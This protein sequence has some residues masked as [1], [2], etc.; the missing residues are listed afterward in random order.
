MKIWIS[1]ATYNRKKITE[2][3]LRQLATFKQDS[4]LHVTD[5]HSSEYDVAFLKNL[6]ADSV[7]QPVSKLGIHHIRCQEMEQFLQSDYDLCYFTDNDAFHDP[8]YVTKLKEIYNRYQL[9]STLYNTRW[10]FNS[11]VN[12]D[13]DVLFRKTMPGI[14]QLYDKKMATIIVEQLHKRGRPDYAWDYRFIEWL[15]T[16]TIATN[17]S[18]VEHFGV[19]GIHNTSLTD[20]DRDRAHNPTMF[21]QQ[22]RPIIINLL[23]NLT[24]TISVV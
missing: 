13:G 11:T 7:E 5:D 3:V 6:G 23:N 9:P 8:M 15:N 1:L 10:H 18:Y 2:I 19:G 16:L 17:I 20:F 24:G 4:F 12:Q 22:Q 21:L 14:S